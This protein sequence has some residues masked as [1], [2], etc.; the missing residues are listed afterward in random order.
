MTSSFS[1]SASAPCTNLASPAKTIQRSSTLSISSPDTRL[2]PISQSASTSLSSVPATPQSTPRA[3][4]DV[5]APNPSKSSTVVTSSTWPHS[6]S[7]TSKR[8]PKES[9]S[10]GGFN[11]PPSI[12]HQTN[13]PSYPSSARRSE[14]AGMAHSIASHAP[15]SASPATC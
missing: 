11:P 3:P 10:G 1:V 9:R 15:S 12:S 7:S 4:P 5:S 8:S 6:P 13:P 2:P 14:L